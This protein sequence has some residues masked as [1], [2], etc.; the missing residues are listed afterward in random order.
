MAHDLMQYSEMVDR[1]LR[2]VVRTALER[3]AEEGLPGQHHFYIAF[4]TQ[5]PGVEI[6]DNLRAQ[7]PEEMTIVLQNQ[8]WG[9]EI[10]DDGFQVTLSFG[11]RGQ[12]LRIPYQSL[13]SFLDPSVQFALQFGQPPEAAGDDEAADGAETAPADEP[14]ATAEPAASDGGDNVV[15]L[16]RFRKD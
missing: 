2:G 7:Y 16:D 1:A 6:P 5:Y 8:F 4:Q 9:L 10:D 12:R 15:T 13:N 14:A 3:I 11:G